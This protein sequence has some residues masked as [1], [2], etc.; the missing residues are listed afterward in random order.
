MVEATDEDLATRGLLLEMALEA[1]G[2]IA[3]GEELGVDR[4]VGMMTGGAALAHGLVL[5]DVGAALGGMAL[6]TAF[7]FG[8]QRGMAAHDR[9]PVM[10]IVAI[11]AGQMPFR[12]RMPM[13]Q[14]ERTADIEV[15]GEADVGRLEGIDDQLGIAAGLDVKIAW[16]MTGLA[17]DVDGIRALGLKS[18]MTGGDEVADQLIVAIRAG[19]GTDIRCAG[20]GG[21]RHD[22]TGE[23]GAG[24]ED[25]GQ[26]EN[27][28]REESASIRVG[29]FRAG[30]RVSRSREGRLHIVPGWSMRLSGLAL[31]LSVDR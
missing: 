1:E 12:H 3:L 21:R 5:E 24:E 14:A 19:A 7:V 17:A 30:C 23:G 18:R 11:G 29:G 8:E 16:A 9:A 27:D 10:R 25:G 6:V 13:R 4:A 26:G 20:N 15:T 22:C 28:R 2:G 31:L